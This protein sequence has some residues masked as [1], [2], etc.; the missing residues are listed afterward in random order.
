MDECDTAAR[1]MDC[2]KNELPYMFEDIVAA[3]DNTAV[4]GFICLLNKK[5][6]HLKSGG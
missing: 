6:Y 5:E 4:V 2:G 1:V 3:V